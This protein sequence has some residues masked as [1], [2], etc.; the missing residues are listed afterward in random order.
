MQKNTQ[1]QQPVPFY[2]SKRR[3]FAT[4]LLGVGIALTGC[5]T[6]TEPDMVLQGF[7]FD[8]KRDH[9]ADSI[10]LLRYE[11]GDSF[12]GIHAGLD[13]PRYPL[14]GMNHTRMHSYNAI[15]DQRAVAQSLM[16]KWRIRASGKVIQQKVD[17]RPLLPPDMTAQTLTFVI[18]GE[19]LRIFIVTREARPKGSLPDQKTIL[20]ASWVAYEIYPTKPS[21]AAP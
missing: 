16:V 17:L 11:Y 1:H 14:Y 2:A 21:G 4:V 18:E 8:G 19:Q 10:D 7:Y 15:R 12:W 5:A 3:G 13:D 9:W 20:S 6:D